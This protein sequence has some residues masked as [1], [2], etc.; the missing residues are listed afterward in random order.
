MDI[1]CLKESFL[2]HKVSFLS[3]KVSFLSDK[4][5]FLCHGEKLISSAECPYNV[6][7]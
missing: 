7:E 5:S 4:V 1:P 6:S 2:S 3:D